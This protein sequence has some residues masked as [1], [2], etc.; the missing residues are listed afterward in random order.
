LTTIQAAAVAPSR[1]FLVLAI[2]LVTVTC[3]AVHVLLLAT[4]GTQMLSMTVPM[5][6][7]SGLCLACTRAEGG[8]RA[9]WARMMAGAASLAMIVLHLVVMP[10]E[11]AAT[12]HEGAHAG[13]DMG[14]MSMGST[15]PAKSSSLGVPHDLMQIGVALA[16]LQLLLIA[17][18]ALPWAWQRRMIVKPCDT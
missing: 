4:T 18:A 13:M 8:P 15:A 17:G 16:G 12:A 7:L 2:R 9:R 6:V 5:F 1:G 14:S 10:P 11:F 3:F